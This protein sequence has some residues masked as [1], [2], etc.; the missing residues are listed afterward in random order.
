MVDCTKVIKPVLEKSG[1]NSLRDYFLD[2]W[3]GAIVADDNGAEDFLKNFIETND[4]EKILSRLA[5][6]KNFLF[7][8]K[9]SQFRYRLKTQPTNEDGYE[10]KLVSVDQDVSLVYIQAK[11]DNLDFISAELAGHCRII[12]KMGFDKK[13]F[14]RWMNCRISNKIIC[15]PEVKMVLENPLWVEG[16]LNYNS[17]FTSNEYRLWT[18]KYEIDF[19]IRKRF[20]VL[21]SDI[22]K[23]IKK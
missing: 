12:R 10:F 1:L 11:R 4:K 19:P 2:H 9:N 18:K 16:F 20:R 22:I 8:I 21:I 15:I 6:G 3:V 5:R 23:H 7:F 14:K 17:H 13:Y